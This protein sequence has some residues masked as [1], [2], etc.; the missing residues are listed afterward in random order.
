LALV[1]AL[2]LALAFTVAGATADRDDLLMNDALLLGRSREH[3]TGFR[4]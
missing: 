1:L 2:A 3:S 4:E